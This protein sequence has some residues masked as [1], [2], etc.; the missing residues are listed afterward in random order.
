MKAYTIRYVLTTLAVI[1]L[2]AGTTRVFARAVGSQK[3]SGAP[4]SHLVLNLSG[5]E[6]GTA[7]PTEAPG[8]T[9]TA[10]PTDTAEPT[11]T[12]A[13]TETAVPT[14]VDDQN[15]D[16]QGDDNECDDPDV[17]LGTVEQISDTA[18]VV[19]GQTYL[20]TPETK[21]EGV[22]VVGDTV[23]GEFVT[24]PD[25]SLTATEIEL[26]SGES[27]CNGDNQ[28]DD[29]QGEDHSGFD[30]DSNDDD[31]GGGDHSGGDDDDSGGGDHSGGGDDD[32]GGGDD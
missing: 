31:S 19:S 4:R 5:S 26:G 25:G 14:E 13:P 17:P 16:D 12:V 7:E 3:L 32:E 2:I 27:M 10:T 20:V 22:I 24:N 11:E 21:I 30:N 9:D 23:K 15:D 6:T 1:V 8:S 18:W 29:D 28:G